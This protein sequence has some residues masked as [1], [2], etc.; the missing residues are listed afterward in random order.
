MIAQ[1]GHATS[2]FT[3]GSRSIDL[4]G[5]EVAT[6]VA[7]TADN[8]AA[9]LALT[10]F[11]NFDSGSVHFGNAQTLLVTRH[12]R[13]GSLDETFCEAGYSRIALP[14]QAFYFKTP[15]AILADGKI[16]VSLGTAIVRMNADV[17][18]DNSYGSDGVA[19]APAPYHSRDQGQVFVADS[20]GTAY[21]AISVPTYHKYVAAYV[22]KY[23]NQVV[24][25]FNA[26]GIFDESFGSNGIARLATITS[27]SIFDISIAA[28]ENIYV[29]GATRNEPEDIQLPFSD[30]YVA[31]L[32]TDSSTDLTFA[33]N[34]VY[35]QRAD[36]RH[37]E[38]FKTVIP[39]AHGSITVV[40][41]LNKRVPSRHSDANHPWSLVGKGMFMKLNGDGPP[42][43]SFGNNGLI[44][45]EN[46][47]DLYFEGTAM[48][49][50]NGNIAVDA[51]E[52][53]SYKLRVFDS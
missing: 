49:L 29:A 43:T 10:D 45:E 52:G 24:Y 23:D 3:D 31:R 39:N 25:R 4:A 38:S 21:V 36:N 18:L 27:A 48:V 50:P 5:V 37:H 28:D 40:G 8:K 20:N 53:T 1:A 41:E 34:G 46:K 42:M 47:E 32:N 44:W 33:Q 30:G 6:G 17:T 22:P 7:A 14:E 9:L 13:N 15:A 19:R 35:F 2:Q 26:S 16:L 51:N 11:V 12:N